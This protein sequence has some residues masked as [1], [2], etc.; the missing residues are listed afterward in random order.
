MC[1]V[2]KFHHNYYVEMVMAIYSFDS[3]YIVI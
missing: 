2:M 3:S 1:I